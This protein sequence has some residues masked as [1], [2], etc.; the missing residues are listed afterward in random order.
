MKTES[1]LKK[2]EHLERTMKKLDYSEDYET[3][4]EVY[5]LTSAHY[6][7]TALHKKG[8]VT[9][10]RDVKHNRLFSFLNG[11]QLGVHTSEIRDAVKKLEDMRPGHV[12]GTGDNGKSA[13]KAEQLFLTIQR[14]CSEII[15]KDN[16]K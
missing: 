16:E 10:V 11:E 12:Y 1:H 4:I 3:L 5:M 15:R 8:A 6:I 2:I 13:K 7:N 9:E 14:R